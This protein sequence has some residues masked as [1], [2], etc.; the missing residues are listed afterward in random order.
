[1]DCH[2][3]GGTMILKKICDYGG[4]SWGWKCFFCG[5]ITDQVEEH[6]EW[7]KIGRDQNKIG[8]RHSVM[9]Y[10]DGVGFECDGM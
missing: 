3:C 6:L 5:E 10:R 9:T 1:M 4:Y 8:G 2:R 7:L